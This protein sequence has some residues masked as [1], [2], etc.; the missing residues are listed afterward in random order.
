[1]D[2][3]Y[4]EFVLVEK[5]GILEKVLD[6]FFLQRLRYIRQLGPCYLV[7]PGAEH[8]RFQHCIGTMWLVKKA[9]SQL[10][11]KGFSIDEKTENALLFSAMI[12]DIGHSP[13]SHALEGVI[14][15]KNHEELTFYGLKVLCDELNLDKEIVSEAEKILRKEHEKPYIYQLISSQLDCDRLDY[16]KRDAFYTGISFGNVDINR[17]LSSATIENEELVWEYKSLNALEAYV[18]FRYQ[19]YWAVYF[20]RTN[21][22]IQ[23]M[24]RKIIERLKELIE[25]GEKPEID[26]VL[27]HTLKT[28]DIEGF[29]HLTDGNIIGSIYSSF[30]TTKDPILKELC[31][32]FVKRKVFKT[33]EAKPSDLIALKEKVERAGY[34]PRYFFDIVESAKVA[35]AYYTPSGS[36]VIKVKTP[37]VI[38]ELS[39]VAPTDAI[40]AL[41]RKVIK[42]FAVLPEECCG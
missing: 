42:V 22:S 28:K 13:F 25:N 1:M 30:K 19:M 7:Y 31:E 4:G 12:H 40:K 36:E 18:M 37:E 26:P 5:N 23:V 17:I 14:L 10:R 16:L 15:S 32:R 6:S 29:F 20:H 3:V 21:L 34:D 24:L 8:T 41:S 39:N 2:P 11:M 33:V 27:Y 38:D 9:V 35:Y